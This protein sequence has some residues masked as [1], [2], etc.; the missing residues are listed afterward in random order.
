MVWWTPVATQ[1]TNLNQPKPTP[2]NNEYALVKLRYKLPGES[3]SRL[4]SQPVTAENTPLASMQQQ[5][6]SFAVAVA[7]FAQLL[8]GSNYAGDWDYDQVIEVAQANKGPDHYGYR[9]EFIQLVRKAQIS[10][11]L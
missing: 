10:K 6:V 8:K 3:E 7:G 5:E 9:T 11:G 1:S 2:K 4:L